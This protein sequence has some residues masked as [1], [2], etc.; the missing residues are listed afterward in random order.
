MAVKVYPAF[1][2][3]K[4]TRVSPDRPVARVCPD[5]PVTRSRAKVS[6]ESPVT[7]GNRVPPATPGPRVNPASRDS[8][9]RSGPEVTTGDLVSL[10]TLENLVAQVLK[11]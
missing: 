1:L 4:V 5:S 3:P 10:A 9:G 6:R 2:D 8:P 11:V 7:P